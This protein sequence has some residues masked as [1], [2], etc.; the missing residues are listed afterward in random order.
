LADDGTIENRALICELLVLRIGFRGRKV[1]VKSGDSIDE[2]TQ[3]ISRFWDFIGSLGFQRK[4]ME[5]S[6]EFVYKG[7]VNHPMPREGVLPTHQQHAPQIE[8]P[9]VLPFL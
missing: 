5:T 7:C 3:L 4:R 1:F 9:P 6:S 8:G 2:C